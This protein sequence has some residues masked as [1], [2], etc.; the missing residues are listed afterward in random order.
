MG[1]S[2]K[3]E[4]R[5]GQSL[6]MT[7]QL[8]QAIKLLQM[9]NFEL[10]S[11][12]E[13]ELERNPLLDRANSTETNEPSVASEKSPAREE[14]EG[15]AE[16]AAAPDG[17]E[18]PLMESGWASMRQ[19]SG[20]AAPE[21][22]DFAQNLS[23]ETSLVEHLED[24]LNL[25]FS[26]P[27]SRLI[28][29]HLLGH[30]NDAGY[31]A[32]DLAS[33]AETLGAPEFLLEDILAVMQSFEP[34]GVFA[35]DLQECLMLQLREKNRLDPAMRVLI[36][37]LDLVAKRDYLKLQEL[38]GV[39]HDDMRDMIAELRALNPKPGNSFGSVVV[40]PVV[41]DVFVRAAQDGTWLVELNTETLPR[42]LVNNQY[43]AKVSANA[44]RETD[45]LY[46]ADCMSNA[47]WLVKS[48][49]QRARTILKVAREIVR[50]QDSFL[51]EGVT[52]LK[53]LN[54]RNVADAI[55]MHESTVS[56]VTSNKYIA[57]PRGIFEMKY[58]FTTAIQAT[59]SGDPGHSAEAVR[60][61]IRKLIEA[62]TA[63]HI[64]SDDQIVD[65]LRAEGI[66]I[67]RRTVAKYREALGFGSSVQRRREKRAMA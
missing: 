49:D 50:Q 3:L 32:T 41:P 30:L 7:P 5:Q 33:I 67:A 25:T 64:F 2:Q 13:A 62:E 18:G 53:P 56:R 20:Q 57:T 10:Q 39:D 23:R 31:L 11:Y 15:D 35:R 60:F 48:L 6:V 61:R 14:G 47:T 12:V 46:L 37:H 54:L 43:F 22:L 21:G 36:Q 63:A 8:Q 55:S 16:P 51:L 40:Q 44:A 38:C 65:I 66:E 52:G 4:M 19:S 9:S 45:K 42:I 27:A 28:G 34:A 26:D 24:Q 17:T 29:Q 58:F 1:L 59:E